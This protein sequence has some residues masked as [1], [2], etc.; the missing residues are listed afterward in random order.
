MAHKPIIFQKKHPCPISVKEDLPPGADS[1][2][3]EWKCLNGLR[4]G[5]G[6]CRR[7][8]ILKTLLN[9]TTVP[10]IVFNFG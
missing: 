8:V 1:S 7:N 3:P 10:K 2:W 9:S 5:T 6:Y 4:S